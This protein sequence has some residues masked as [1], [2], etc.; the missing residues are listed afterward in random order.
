MLDKL[1]E[2]PLRKELIHHPLLKEVRTGMPVSKEAVAT[3]LGQWWYPLD[4]F[5]TFLSRSI[6]VLPDRDMQTALSKILYQELGEGRPDNS[7][8]KLFITTMADA[9]F[10]EATT[11]QAP[12]F[13]ETRK[14]VELYEETSHNPLRALGAVYGTEVADLAMVSGVGQMV[15]SVS[16]AKELPWVDIHVQQEPDHV[17]QA[18]EALEPNFTPEEEDQIVRAAED[19]WRGWISFFD[20]IRA[21]ARAEAPVAAAAH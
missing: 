1:S 17:E 8:G 20:R 16:G 4:Y 3:L 10:D 21:E 5:P 7:H 12:A 14:L 11:T 19:M 6:S 13:E 2:H 9:G 15:R 18:S